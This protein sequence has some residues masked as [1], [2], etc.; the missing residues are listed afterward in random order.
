MVVDGL[1]LEDDAFRID[2]GDKDD[3]IVLTDDDQIS[4]LSLNASTA[5]WE[6]IR[7]LSHTSLS[8]LIRVDSPADTASWEECSVPEGCC[9][10]LMPSN[11]KFVLTSRS[12]QVPWSL[13]GVIRPE[14][15]H[16]FARTRPCIIE[17]E[18]EEEEEC[19]EEEYQ[20]AEM[21]SKGR[22]AGKGSVVARTVR[23]PLALASDV[24]V[25]VLRLLW[26][27]PARSSEC[28]PSVLSP[29]LFMAI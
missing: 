22:R 5:S 11:N 28:S 23:L 12:I 24:V 9:G 8:M 3:F 20:E 14:S 29:Y 1:L 2:G 10:G 26:A 21:D 19:G 25:L 27:P 17:C 13:E 7:R 18:E 4:V 15:P 16:F 6:D